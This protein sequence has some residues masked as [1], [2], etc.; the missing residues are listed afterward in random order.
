MASAAA[1]PAPAFT[2]TMQ[3]GQ[4]YD[5]VWL[6]HTQPDDPRCEENGARSEVDD[7]ARYCEPCTRPWSSSPECRDC[8]D[9]VLGAEATLVTRAV[10]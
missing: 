6:E 8:I 5:Q 7:C 3:A 4:C 10:Q 1:A 2:Y 9:D